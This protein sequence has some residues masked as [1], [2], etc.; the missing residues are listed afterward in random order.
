MM[1]KLLS[2]LLAAGMCLSMA[3]CTSADNT[4]SGSTADSGT[5]SGTEE[6]A[7][8]VEYIKDKGTLVV[9]ITEFAPMDYN[10]LMIC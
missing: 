1:K 8:D 7:S 2:L 3:A 6:T 9:G 5:S 10:R 4:S